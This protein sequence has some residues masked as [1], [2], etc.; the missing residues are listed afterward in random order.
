[1]GEVGMK[2][3]PPFHHFDHATKLHTMLASRII[4][5]LSQAIAIKGSASLLLSGGSTPI[6]LLEEL[7]AIR[8]AWEKVYIGLVDERWIAPSHK[9]SNECMIKEY[10]LQNEARSAHF[11][12]MYCEH[13]RDQ[14]TKHVAE[15]YARLFPC[16]VI[17][18]GMGTDGHTASLFPFNPKLDEAFERDSSDYLVMLTPDSAPYERM[19]I[20]M[21]AMV[22][23]EHIYLHIEGNKKYK[24]YQEALENED[25]YEMPIRAVLHDK[26]LG[27]EVFYA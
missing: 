26:T 24:V 27:C 14:C 5:D 13:E 8:F 21:K 12:G 4:E 16:D 23:A 3:N 11:V 19:S 2:N 7:S 1:M 25:S 15:A 10:L 17:V 18:L 9:D 6:P 20:T 22:E